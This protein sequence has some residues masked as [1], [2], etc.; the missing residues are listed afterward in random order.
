MKYFTQLSKEQQKELSL[1]LQGTISANIQLICALA[2]EYEV[3]RNEV[4]ELY[5]TLFKNHIEKHDMNKQKKYGFMN[6]LFKKMEG[7]LNNE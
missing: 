5:N 3:D 4:F 7:K 1:S 2:D 6:R